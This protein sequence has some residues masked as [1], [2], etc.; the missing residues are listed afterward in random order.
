MVAL[1]WR[2]WWV[3]AAATAVVAGVLLGGI[4]MAA[5]GATDL[6]VGSTRDVTVRVT[7]APRPHTG[8]GGQWWSA[9]AVVTS[10]A[11]RARVTL[12]GRGAADF[13]MGDV[14][15][16]RA[17]VGPPGARGE[18]ATLRVA[19]PSR[20]TRATSPSA[21]VR[22]ALRSVAG[23]DDAGWLL[24]GMALGMDEG[25]SQE[26]RDDMRG[27]GLSHLTAVS[28]AN[29]AVLVVLV[30]WIGG[31]LRLG[32][33]A[34][35]A[36]AA[37]VLIS[38]AVT[39]GPQPSVLRAVAM[40]GLT[41]VAGLTGG[42]RSAGHVLQVSAVALLLIDPWLAYS[43]G[44]MLSIAATAGLILLID[45]GP[46]AATVAAQVATFPILLAIGGSVG[47]RTVLANVLV[48]P[49]AMVIPV[50]GLATA[51]LEGSLSWGS[52]L[53]AAGR[54]MCLLVLRVAG[55]D[56]PGQLHWLPGWPGV[57]LAAVVAA[58]VLML[59]RRRMVAVAFVL[60][61]GVSWTARAADPWPPPD[62]WIV[63]CDVGQGDGLVV[64]SAGRI[65]VVDAGPDPAAMDSC[66]RRLDVGRIDLLVLTHFH[67]DHVGGLAGVLGGR[68]VGQV[69]VSP[70]R[71]P[72]E[73]FA[74][75]WPTLSGIPVSVPAAGTQVRVGDMVLTVIWPQRVIQAGSV[76]NNASISFL[77]AGPQGRAVFLGDTEPEAHAAI[78]RSAD[79]RADVVKVPHHGSAQFLAGLPRAVSARIALVGVGAANPFGHPAA[80]TL[81]AWQQSGA[82]VYTTEMNGDIAITSDRA[83]AV[84]GRPR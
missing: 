63:A 72:P 45:R 51:L 53:V 32:R 29:C 76:P 54:W 59:G 74:T 25:L 40:A 81:Q 3:A 16:A 8:V 33:A 43:V 44:F 23:D 60:I 27:S 17:V 62:W 64:R 67:D 11:Q 46:L 69:W 57:A 77:L 19:G 55:W 38:F 22:N 20:V 4:H 14:L 42:R 15:G 36:G 35:T 5:V 78:L 6:E 70:C 30:H 41:L 73:Q 9:Q 39:V 75:A 37:V 66:L 71:E 50:V 65:L 48:S 31:W 68:S 28:G 80:Q 47:L 12:T 34:R 2:R 56:L 49:L 79:V 84:R 24:S 26:A 13:G 58:A 1:V 52:P 61:G 82:T 10:G 7:S 18:S 83:V 21:R